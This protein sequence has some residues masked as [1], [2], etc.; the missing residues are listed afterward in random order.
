MVIIHFS[1]KITTS[2]DHWVASFDQDQ[3]LLNRDGITTLSRGF[4]LNDPSQVRIIDSAPS[5]A[6]SEANM[7][8]NSATIDDSGHEVE[9]TVLA[10]FSGY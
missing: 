8:G 2:F 7:A 3:T 1:F 4:L 9:S 10:V 5:L 6:A